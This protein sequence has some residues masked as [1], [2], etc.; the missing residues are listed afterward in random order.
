MRDSQAEQAPASFAASS[1]FP[2]EAQRMG[3][4]RLSALFTAAAIEFMPIMISR[5]E[6]RCQFIGFGGTGKG[7]CR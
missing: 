5:A 3:Y 7:I 6:P 1:G 2:H 4:M